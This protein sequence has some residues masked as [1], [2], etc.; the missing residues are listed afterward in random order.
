MY[1]RNRTFISTGATRARCM[2]LHD[3]R[4]SYILA[5]ASE[6]YNQSK[7]QLEYLLLRLITTR[8]LHTDSPAQFL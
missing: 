4:I 6:I 8:N 3:V 7:V 5:I 2:T 1:T